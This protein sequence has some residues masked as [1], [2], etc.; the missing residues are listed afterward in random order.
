[1]NPQI[2]SLRFSNSGKLVCA[3][4]NDGSLNAWIFSEAPRASVPNREITETEASDASGLSSPQEAEEE[5]DRLKSRAPS[6]DATPEAEEKGEDQEGE[7][8]GAEDGGQS[9]EGG[10]AAEGKSQ[11]DAD[12]GYGAAAS[13]TEDVAAAANGEMSASGADIG[14]ASEDVVMTD[15]ANPVA[16]NGSA[17]PSRQPTPPAPVIPAPQESKIDAAAEARRTQLKRFRHMICAAASLLSLS[18]DP[19]GR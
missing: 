12:M 10:E 19:T 1:M 14:A 4:S 6:R 18:L 13:A 5:P 11:E 15:P 17:A 9:A 16:A 2:N 7:A 3:V 8:R